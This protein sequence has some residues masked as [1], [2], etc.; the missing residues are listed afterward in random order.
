MFFE[1]GFCQPIRGISFHIDTGKNPHIYCNAPSYGPREAEVMRNLVES[2]DES[3]VVEEDD[4]PCFSLVF[5]S[6]KTH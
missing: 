2:L 3:G 4:V 5:L 1:D 6:D